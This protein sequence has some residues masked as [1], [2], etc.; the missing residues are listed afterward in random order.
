MPSDFWSTVVT[1]EVQVTEVDP[2]KIDLSDIAPQYIGAKSS[3]S[4]L[5]SLWAQE[6][7][8]SPTTTA[9][10]TSNLPISS[11]PVVPTDATDYSYSEVSF[12]DNHQV[13]LEKQD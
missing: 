11:A 9:S 7:E 4:D 2:S 13:D 6:D 5:A 12:D 3:V 1:K 8:E 10:T